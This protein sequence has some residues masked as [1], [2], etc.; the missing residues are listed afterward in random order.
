[1]R[2]S[3]WKRLQTYTLE[4]CVSS[5]LKRLITDAVIVKTNDYSKLL[6]R[7]NKQQYLLQDKVC[8]VLFYLSIKESDYVVL[9]LEGLWG[10]YV[11]PNGGIV[12]FL[13]EC[14]ENCFPFPSYS[15]ITTQVCFKTIKQHSIEN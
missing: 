8:S 6:L 14:G 15:V 11:P 9:E 1:M 10:R 13:E 2:R 3:S 7:L 4:Y 12:D 5:A